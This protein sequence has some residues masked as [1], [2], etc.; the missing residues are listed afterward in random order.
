MLPE[1]V[2]KFIGSS[3]GVSV[4]KVEKEPIRRFAD[5]TDDQNPLYYDEKYAKKSR[6]GSIIAPPGLISAP[7]FNRPKGGESI[8]DPDRG[9]RGALRKAGFVSPGA[10]DAG[11]EYEFFNPVKAGDTI[12]SSAVI[13]DIIEREGRTSKM[14]FIFTETTFTNQKDELVAKSRSTLILR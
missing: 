11:I 8:F 12:T 10:I 7:W 9:V 6:Y 13:K 4:F 2:T 5:S 14:A 3:A 1:E